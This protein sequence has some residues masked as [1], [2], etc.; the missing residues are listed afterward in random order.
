MKSVVAPASL[1][2]HTAI[3]GFSLR[4]VLEMVTAWAYPEPCSLTMSPFAVQVYLPGSTRLYSEYLSFFDPRVP[5]P[6]T[7]NSKPPALDL[8][9]TEPWGGSDVASRSRSCSLIVFDRTVGATTT[10][11]S[12]AMIPT[13]TAP[14]SKGSRRFP[15]PRRSTVAA[16]RGARLA[17]RHRIRKSTRP[18][19]APLTLR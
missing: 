6:A 9:T 17:S 5:Q 2:P 12:V 7:M 14:I 15:D 1:R 4:S 18:R 8:A 16:R 3:T 13:G 11:V 10:T 19:R